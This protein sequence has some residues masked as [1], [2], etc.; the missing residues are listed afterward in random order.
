VQS[1][2]QETASNHP[3]LEPLLITQ[4]AGGPIG[5]PMNEDAES[6]CI[7]DWRASLQRVVNMLIAPD[8]LQ[9]KDFEHDEAVSFHIERLLNEIKSRWAR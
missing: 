4:A 1:F 6:R 8:Q 5:S 2:L 9:W 3:N 7:S